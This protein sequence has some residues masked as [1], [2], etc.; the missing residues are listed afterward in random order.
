MPN[1][2]KSLCGDAGSIAV[3]LSTRRGPR[4]PTAERS[5]RL[6]ALVQFYFTWK[7]VKIS[8]RNKTKVGAE[9]NLNSTP[10]PQSSIQKNTEI[11]R[12]KKFDLP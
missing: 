10:R 11:E 7:Q 5:W 9:M 1:A 6:Q 3:G 8:V 2:I 12:N 4:E